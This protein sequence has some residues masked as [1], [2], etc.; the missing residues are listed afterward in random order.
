MTAATGLLGV[1]FFT[2]AGFFEKAFLNLTA[3]YLSEKA[4]AFLATALGTALVATFLVITFVTL[5]LAAGFAAIFL[6]TG[7]ALET[8]FAAGFLTLALTTAAF[9]FLDL[10]ATLGLL[11][12][13][14]LFAAGF[15]AFIR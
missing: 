9:L 13:L 7:F 1:C 10:A 15:L 6:A 4:G 11:G 12:F 8:D 3:A 14:L 5:R 2:G